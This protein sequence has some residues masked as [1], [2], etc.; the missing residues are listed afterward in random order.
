V[1]QLAKYSKR[2]V[3]N[4]LTDT[5]HPCQAL[6]FAMTLDE[7]R[8]PLGK[9]KKIVFVGD[10]NNVCNSLMFLCAKLGLDFT[11]ACPDGYGPTASVRKAVSEVTRASGSTITVTADPST[12]VKGAT[13][14]YTD[15][16]TSMGQEK[17][18]E[19][20]NKAFAA[21][22]VNEKLMACAPAEA[23]VSHCLPA[24]RG[25]EIT[26]AVLDSKASIAFDEAENRLHVQKA[27]IFHLFS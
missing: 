6:A 13:A 14:I 10:C 27:V 4:A 26:S 18:Q 11:V 5:D 19:K 24:H 3:I 16:W 15:V 9:N 23:I 7:H 1:E 8:G 21:F 25:E 20:R 17:E 2:P 22:S 12:A